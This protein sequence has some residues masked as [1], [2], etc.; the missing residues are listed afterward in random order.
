MVDINKQGEDIH[1]EF[2]QNYRYPH[3]PY[4]H[5]TGYF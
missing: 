3:H 5:S 4:R 2:K 1:E